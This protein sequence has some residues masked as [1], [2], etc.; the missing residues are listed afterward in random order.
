MELT[1]IKKVK[2]SDHRLNP[3]RTKHTLSDSE[4]T[5]PFPVFSEL[6][7]AHSTGQEGYYLLYM[8]EDGSGTDTWHLSPEDALHQA[9]W[10]FEVLPG[11]WIEV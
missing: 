2:L 8:C 6:A 4:G 9:E 7:I 10:E 11:E 1:T 5:R 3:G